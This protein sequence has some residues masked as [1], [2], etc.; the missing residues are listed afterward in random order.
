[1]KKCKKCGLAKN[2]IE[3]YTFKRNGKR[4]FGINCIKWNNSI[5]T[6]RQ[7][8]RQIELKRKLFENLGGKCKDCGNRDLRVIDFHHINRELKNKKFYC[9][10]SIKR[11]RVYL[12]EKENLE[13][14]C[15]NCHRIHN[16]KTIWANKYGLK[17]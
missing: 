6:K 1:M 14:L 15:A 12:K 7:S 10:S 4:R 9:A 11:M 13:P 8:V 16:F 2:D 3:F 17:Y 5:R